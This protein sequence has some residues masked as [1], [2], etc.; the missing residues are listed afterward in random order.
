[1][2]RVAK[3][4]L[5]GS[6]ILCAATIWGVHYLQKKEHED[7]YKGVLRDDAR[8]AAKLQERQER[9]EESLKKQEQYERVQPVRQEG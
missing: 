5:A 2:S 7:M 8:R 9:L 6:A 3:A 1:M 4:T